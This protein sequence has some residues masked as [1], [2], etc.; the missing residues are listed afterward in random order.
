[1]KWMVRAQW[2]G[3]MRGRC[4]SGMWRVSCGG[5]SRGGTLG[6]ANRMKLRPGGFSMGLR[7]VRV[8]CGIYAM[9]FVAV[10]GD[11]SE[12]AGQDESLRVTL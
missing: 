1:M 9:V 12:Y 5:P 2:G 4:P 7:A 3:R 8:F 6:K 11:C 10:A